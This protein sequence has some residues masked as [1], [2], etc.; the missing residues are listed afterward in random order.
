MQPSKKFK[1]LI[2]YTTLLAAT[3][4]EIANTAKV[5]FLGSAAVLTLSIVKCVEVS[6]ES[7]YTMAEKITFFLEQRLHLNK[8]ECFEMVAQ[9]HEILCIILKLY[10]GSEIQGVLPTALLYDIAK[11]TE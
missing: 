9:I 10:S 2:A 7:L 6:P 4:Q 5:P 8:D 3:A 1:N 11:F